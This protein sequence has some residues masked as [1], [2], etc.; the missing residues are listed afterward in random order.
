[1]M[2]PYTIITDAYVRNSRKTVGRELERVRNK[3]E[4]RDRMELQS[5][6]PGRIVMA[7]APCLPLK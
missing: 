5:L 7:D 4:K 1:M 2:E 6:V 3:N